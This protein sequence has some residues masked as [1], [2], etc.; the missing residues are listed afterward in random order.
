MES[1]EIY[2]RECAKVEGEEV[3]ELM[4]WI[5]DSERCGVGDGFWFADLI[6]MES[7]CR[8]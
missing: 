4:V 8:P 6:E 3:C 7:E 2:W 1:V 5:G